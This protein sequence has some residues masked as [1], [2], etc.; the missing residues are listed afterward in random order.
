M[1]KYIDHTNLKATAT[2]DDIEKLCLEAKKHNFA[3]VC[4]NPAYVSFCK[5]ILKTSHV[6]ICTVVGFPLGANESATKAFEAV[7]AIKNGADEIDMVINIGNA[8]AHD[9]EAVQKDIEEVVIACGKKA[10]VKVIL[11]TCYL[12]NEE[13]I[14]GCLCAQKAGAT[15]VKTSTG[16]GSD[17]AT[18]EHIILMK[19]TVGNTMKIKAAGGIRDKKTALTMIEN[20]ADRL[21]TSNGVALVE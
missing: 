9:W 10:I 14:A 15:F 6:K 12:T 7:Q 1:N 5:Q 13:I 11:E 20:G 18:I 4:V 19:K 21:G 16:F 2:K 3:S 17:G 8:K